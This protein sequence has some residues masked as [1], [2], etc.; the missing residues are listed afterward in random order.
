MVRRRVWKSVLMELESDGEKVG[1][2]GAD[3]GEL[4]KLG[5]VSNVE[6][7]AAAARYFRPEICTLA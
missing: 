3:L 5:N 2:T 4:E 6:G 1:W 7:S